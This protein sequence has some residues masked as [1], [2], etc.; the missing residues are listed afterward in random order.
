MHDKY[1]LVEKY[2]VVR[3]SDLQYGCLISLLLLF[4]IFSATTIRI[5]KHTQTENYFTL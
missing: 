4:L 1:L 3:T 5:L 2:E